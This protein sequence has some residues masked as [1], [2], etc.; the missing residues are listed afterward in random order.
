MS[1]NALA[2][3]VRRKLSLCVVLK[4]LPPRVIVLDC[5]AGHFFREEEGNSIKR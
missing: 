1:P 3:Q 2:R 5:V 4:V